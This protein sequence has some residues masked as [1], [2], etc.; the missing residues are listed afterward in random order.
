[1]KEKK[2][3]QRCSELKSQVE[4]RIKSDCSFLNLS[5]ALIRPRSYQMTDLGLTEHF[6]SE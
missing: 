5:N 2:E 3:G 1:M 4:K 6:I